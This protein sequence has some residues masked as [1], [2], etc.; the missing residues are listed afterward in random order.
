MSPQP[1]AFGQVQFDG[2]SKSSGFKE[3]MGKTLIE[4]KKTQAVRKKSR[5][6]TRGEV[7]RVL[8]CACATD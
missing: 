2:A 7:T 6:R 8:D 3:A 5:Y 4:D 1:R